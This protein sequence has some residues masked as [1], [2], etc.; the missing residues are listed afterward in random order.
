MTT[1]QVLLSRLFLRL[2]LLKGSSCSHKTPNITLCLDQLPADVLA[3][4]ATFLAS[5][6]RNAFSWTCRT[7]FAAC[8]LVEPSWRYISD[9]NL[10]K[11]YQTLSTAQNTTARDTIHYENDGFS[12][13]NARKLVLESNN[14]D[15][16][17][18]QWMLQQRDA[19]G[20]NTHTQFQSLL[21]RLEHV[22]KLA[23]SGNSV[24]GK[25][26]L[27]TL[28]EQF[29]HYVKTLVADWDVWPEHVCFVVF[30][31]V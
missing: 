29:G 30:F 22:Q 18:G 10:H 2:S 14:P 7:I 20:A 25:E 1:L 31:V 16:D 28:A 27:N 24:Q 26:G 23:I 6:H 13:L 19:R 4:I 15:S 21:R 12:W 8:L 9:D 17:I 3:H 5:A 11:L